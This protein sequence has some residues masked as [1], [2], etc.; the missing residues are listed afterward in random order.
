MLKLYY[1]QICMM[2][3]I[4]QICWYIQVSVCF[5]LWLGEDVC[6][7]GDLNL[8]FLQSCFMYLRLMFT[9]SIDNKNCFVESSLKR[10]DFTW[11]CCVI[12][13]KINLFSICE[14]LWKLDSIN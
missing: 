7:L 11:K 4:A 9:I 10:L 12:N 2:L 5:I 14:L 1:A 13:V 6:R 8:A 3:K